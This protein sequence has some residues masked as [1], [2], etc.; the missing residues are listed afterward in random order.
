M[1]KTLLARRETV[2]SRY[3]E[4][5]LAILFPPA[6]VLLNRGPSKEVL[7]SIILTVLGYIPGIIYAMYII[8]S[9]V[10]DDHLS[11]AEGVIWV[12]AK[13][14]KLRRPIHGICSFYDLKEMV[15]KTTGEGYMVRNIK[16][17]KKYLISNL[18]CKRTRVNN[19]LR[20][21]N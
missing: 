20:D 6:A 11:D 16:P 21:E 19:F 18:I 13:K 8:F 17:S 15:K 7:I 14:L 3:V 12:F 9:N 10:T 5:L 1:D 2:S 4:I